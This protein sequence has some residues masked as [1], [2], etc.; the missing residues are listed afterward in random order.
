[1][2][3]VPGYFGDD[4]SDSRLGEEAEKLG[5]VYHSIYP[6]I[7]CSILQ[8]ITVYYHSVYSR[9]PLLIKADLGGGGKVRSPIL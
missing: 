9:F 8:Y 7:S 3:V 5:S 1:M 2:P 6:S 4:Q